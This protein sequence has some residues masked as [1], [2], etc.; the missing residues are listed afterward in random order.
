MFVQDHKDQ[1]KHARIRPAAGF[2]INDG[3]P[4]NG[5]TLFNV[6]AGGVAVSYPNGTKPTSTRLKVGQKLSLIV[7]DCVMHRSRVVRVSQNGFACKFIE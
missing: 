3:R 5:G 4:Y 1:R 2:K 7:A 6:S